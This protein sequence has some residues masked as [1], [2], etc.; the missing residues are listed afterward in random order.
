MLLAKEP[1]G[2][3][4]LDRFSFIASYWWIWFSIQY[5]K[6][7]NVKQ[8]K[9]IYLNL[10]LPMAHLLA[11]ICPLFVNNAALEVKDL[12]IFSLTAF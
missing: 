8:L 7:L 10:L 9:K 6:S 1:L 4:D 2:E 12:D 3:I 11:M 5:H